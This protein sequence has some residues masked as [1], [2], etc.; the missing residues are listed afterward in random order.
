MDN[1]YNTLI[2]K[3][4]DLRDYNLMNKLDDLSNLI[5]DYSKGINPLVNIDTTTN[6]LTALEKTL[7]CVA[8]YWLYKDVKEIKCGSEF[9][10]SSSEKVVHSLTFPNTENK[11][12]MGGEIGAFWQ[13]VEKYKVGINSIL[14]ADAKKGCTIWQSWCA[15]F[16]GFI[17]IEALTNLGTERFFDVIKNSAER[18]KSNFDDNL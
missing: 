5:V 10:N 18:V 6:D 16:C 3:I 7:V 15:I 1:R 9:A 2:Q 8:L 17:W 12:I 13:V 11:K 14:K 4:D